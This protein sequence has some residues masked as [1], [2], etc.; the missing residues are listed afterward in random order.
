[1]SS[2]RNDAH[3]FAIPIVRLISIE[4][5]LN[6]YYICTLWSIKSKI[7]DFSH[8]RD[9]N[10]LLKQK[11]PR[12]YENKCITSIEHMY[13]SQISE[14]VRYWNRNFIFHF[15]HFYFSLAR[16]KSVAATV[17]MATSVHFIWILF[18]LFIVVERQLFFVEKINELF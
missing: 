16:P 9:R 14:A 18:Y 3:I 5:I 7:V 8:L 2:I 15:I 1:M 4:K 17:Y 11:Y 10:I 13:P 12:Y 6:H